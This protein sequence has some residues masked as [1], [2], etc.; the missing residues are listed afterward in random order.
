[1]G[2]T[3]FCK[4]KRTNDF[5]GLPYGGS[6]GGRFISDLVFFLADE[7]EDE[8]AM[9]REGITVSARSWRELLPNIGHILLKNKNNII[10]FV[11]M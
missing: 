7:R 11:N 3:S 8:V 4:C 1:M 9:Y 6:L 2:V 5:T 10:R